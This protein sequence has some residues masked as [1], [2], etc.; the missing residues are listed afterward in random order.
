MI[1]IDEMTVN[2]RVEGDSD[3]DEAAF[4]RLFGKYIQIW[5]EEMRSRQAREARSA[6]ARSLG[7]R[8]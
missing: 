6:E 1:Q 7:V 2:I 8:R 4:A 5:L 3:A